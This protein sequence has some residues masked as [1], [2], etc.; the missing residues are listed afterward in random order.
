MNDS[1]LSV[2]KTENEYDNKLAWLTFHSFTRGEESI[3]K[4]DSLA[5]DITSRYLELKRLM[6]SEFTCSCARCQYEQTRLIN[7]NVP[8]H[9]LK[10]LG[11]IAM[12][13]SRFEAA[14]NIYDAILERDPNNADAFHAKAASFLG[15]ASSLN[16]SKLRHCHGF[17]VQAQ[18]L[19]SQ[20]AAHDNLAKH[21]DISVILQKRNAYRTVQDLSND[22]VTYCSGNNAVWSFESFLNEKVFLTDN[23][24]Q[25]ITPIECEKVIQSAEKYA[26]QTG[27][28]TSRHYAVPTTDIPLHDLADLRPWFYTVWSERIRP[29]LRD[30]FK[31]NTTRASTRTRDIFIH[32]A[33]VV[34]Y[35]ATGGQRNLPPHYD[36]STHSFII[37]LNTDYEGGGTYIHALNKAL[38]PEVAGGMISFCGGELLH[39][40]DSVVEGTRFV[41]VAFCYIDLIKGYDEQTSNC[42][43]SH[44]LDQSAGFSFGFSF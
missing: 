5:D 32:D 42:E 2:N 13:Q 21:A 25:V 18:H 15:R 12:Q 6:G 22:D 33:F 36:E 37:A 28:T 29:I 23:N 24:T 31:L 3:S 16:F 27:W 11:D 40:G 39:S 1:G 14:C 7:G 19:W 30:Q 20:A 9:Q 8:I 35:D 41:I 17:F 43:A 10:R 26:K 4:I 38:K 34:R 44:T